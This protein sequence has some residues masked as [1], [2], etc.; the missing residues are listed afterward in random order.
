MGK[1]PA[2]TVQSYRS[3]PGAGVLGRVFRCLNFLTSGGEI[4]PIR[5]KDQAL[6]K[7]SPSC[8]YKRNNIEFVAP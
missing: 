1:L 2:A 7:L 5:R 4:R 6:S 8:L 3:L